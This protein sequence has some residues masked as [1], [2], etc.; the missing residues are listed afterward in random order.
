MKR[1]GKNEEGGKNG[2]GGKKQRGRELVAQRQD[3]VSDTLALLI[4]KLV[5]VFIKVILSGSRAATPKGMKS[6]RT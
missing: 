1:E 4:H 3:M 2:E 5:I 6:C